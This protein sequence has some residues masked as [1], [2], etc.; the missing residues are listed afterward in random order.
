MR[1]M[2]AQLSH[3]GGEFLVRQPGQ[4]RVSAQDKLIGELLPVGSQ[5]VRDELVRAAP[6]AGGLEQDDDLGS[7]WEIGLEQT[8]LGGATKLSAL[9]GSTDHLG[10]VNAALIC[11]RL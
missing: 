5:R 1:G 4:K 2:G 11:G 9:G 7:R 8:E 10:G 6:Q 3:A